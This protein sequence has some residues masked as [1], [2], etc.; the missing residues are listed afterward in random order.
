[1]EVAKWPLPSS[2]EGSDDSYITVSQIAGMRYTYRRIHQ[3]YPMWV[4]SQYEISSL[5][6]STVDASEIPGFNTYNLDFF[7]LILH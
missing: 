4:I 2:R 1:M 5:I 6:S 3:I 7:T